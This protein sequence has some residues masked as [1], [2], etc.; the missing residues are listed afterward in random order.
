MNNVIGIILIM[1]LFLVALLFAILIT[2]SKRGDKQ[3][4]DNQNKIIEGL[5][6]KL[7]KGESK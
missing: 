2:S 3:I 7:K 5:E 6:E 1:S 4:I